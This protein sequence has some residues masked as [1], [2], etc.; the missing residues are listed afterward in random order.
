MTTK[1]GEVK[2]DIKKLLELYKIYPA[3]KAGAFPADVQGWYYMPVPS[4]LGVSG[5][6]DF[7]GHYR[8]EFFGIEAKAPGKLPT[9]FQALQVGT[10]TMSGG[11]CFVVDGDLQEVEAWLKDELFNKLPYFRGT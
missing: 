9:G 4:A 3:S 7:I 8:G 2:D 11:R 6:P 1:E 5:I 10:I